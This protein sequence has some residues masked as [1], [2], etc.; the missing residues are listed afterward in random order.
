MKSIQIFLA[1]LFLMA[2]SISVNAQGYANSFGWVATNSNSS[3]TGAAACGIQNVIE[4]TSNPSTHSLSGTSALFPSSTGTDPTTTV[5]I[6]LNFLHPVCNLK[7]KV[8]DLDYGPTSTPP[9]ETMT[10]SPM[11]TSISPSISPA[12][13]MFNNVAGTLTPPFG[14]NNTLGWVEFG[15]T[16]LTTVTLTYNRTVGY[17]IFLDSILYDCCDNCICDNKD[18][19][20]IGASS[21]IP[22]SGA[23]SVD[24]NVNSAGVPLSKLNVSIPY[25]E[26]SANSECIKCDPANISKYGKITNLPIIAGVTPTFTGPST[27]GS[28]EIVYEFPV[29]TVVN[30]TISLDLQFP[31]TL[32]L[33][34]CPN[35]VD[36]CV[37]LGLIDKECKIC[38]K[39]LCLPAGAAGSS[40]GS[41]S[42][43][44]KATSTVDQDNAKARLDGELEP[45]N[46]LQITPNPA[47]STLNVRLPNN[48]EASLEVLDLNG[49]NIQSKTVSTTSVSLNISTLSQGTYILKYTSGN[50][51][52]NEKFVK[53]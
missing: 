21:S 51:V 27:S 18:L 53:K 44:K 10:T 28:A 17:G 47:T 25:Y 16:P 41:S 38:E 39:L 12:G 6:T 33:T 29:P 8:N 43:S 42:T 14:V 31:P 20:L 30:Q 15:P 49:K 50:T 11:F 48:A 23:T 45:S 32:E 35:S 3:S 52:I 5:T 37:K 24:V 22:S 19:K 1:A 26:S 40:S 4:L 36:Y 9:T 7:L 46:Q 2:A 34:C 13:P